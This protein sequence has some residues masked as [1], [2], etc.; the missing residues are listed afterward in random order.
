[1]NNLKLI[2]LLFVS[3][4]FF[5][6]SSCEKTECCVIPAVAELHGNWKFVRVNYGFT[7][8]SQT[9]TELGYTE[10]L[11]ID[12]TNERVRR[13]RDG[14]EVENTKFS[15]SELGMS[16]VITFEKDQTYSNYTVFVEDGKTMLSLYERSPV[17]A[18]IA[19][20]GM[21]YYEQTQ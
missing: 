16:K 17:G 14:K 13:Y 2:C 18:V 10:R 11:E 21:Y 9:A 19:D 6:I 5:A 3:T 20:G 7:N 1:M 8:T 4:S 15:V 12:G